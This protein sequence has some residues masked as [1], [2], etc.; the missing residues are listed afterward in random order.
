MCHVQQLVTYLQGQGQAWR[1]KINSLYRV[2]F[3]SGP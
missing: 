2:Y 3:V 1:S